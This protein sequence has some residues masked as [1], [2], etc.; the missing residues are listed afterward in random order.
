LDDI[1]DKF[2]PLIHSLELEVD[3][4]DDLVLIISQTEQAD[5]LRRIANARKRVLALQ[6]LLS[7]KSDVLRILI[8]R[9]EGMALNANGGS[10]GL[11][12]NDSWIA[13][14]RDTSL[15]LGDVQDRKAV[16]RLF[17]R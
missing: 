10:V 1:T 11:V 8:K 5:M 6:R 7:A 2:L 14:I 15:Y 9:L 16:Y 13:M 3:S 4:I 12:I 17:D